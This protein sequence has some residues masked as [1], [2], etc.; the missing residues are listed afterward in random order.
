MVRRTSRTA[1]TLAQETCPLRTSAAGLRR[2]SALA[3]VALPAIELTNIR[4]DFA[5]ALLEGSL[6]KSL[7]VGRDLVG[8]PVPGPQ[9][10]Q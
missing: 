6:R 9:V 4:H 1:C 8:I 2:T 7:R 3:V 5:Q 10:S